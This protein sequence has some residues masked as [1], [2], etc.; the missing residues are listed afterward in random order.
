M[1]L[2]RSFLLVSLLVGLA[3]WLSTPSPH[4][5][6]AEIQY[7][8]LPNVDWN[9]CYGAAPLA[10]T[11]TC[12][13]NPATA[14]GTAAN[15]LA[16][17]SSPITTYDVLQVA[18]GSRMTM[19]TIYTPGGPSGSD[20]GWSASAPVANVT[21]QLDMGCDMQVDTVSRGPSTPDATGNESVSQP[22]PNSAVWN[23]YTFSNLGPT[24]TGE[25]AYLTQIKA[26]PSTFTPISHDRADLTNVWLGTNPLTH[27]SLTDV[28]S[29]VPTK[30]D[31]ILEGSPYRANLKVQQLVLGGNPVPPTNAF[32][33]V[34]SPERIVWQSNLFTPPQ[35]A[36]YYPRWAVLTSQPD[37]VDGSVARI[38]EMRC[39]V[40]GSPP[41][42]INGDCL[43]D[44]SEVAFNGGNPIAA[45]TSHDF[46]VDTVPNAVEVAVGTDPNSNDTDGDGATDYEELFQFTDPGCASGTPKY[47]CGAGHPVDT[48][49]TDG[50]GSWD[51][52]DDLSGFNCVSVNSVCTVAN[53]GDDNTDD[54]C[55][56]IFN[57]S[58]DNTDS[59][60]DFTNSPNTPLTAIYRGDATNPHQDHQGDVCDPDM[61]NDGLNNLAEIGG[62][63]RP[64]IPPGCIAVN[65]P[66]AS[67]AGAGPAAGTLWCLPLSA[68]VPT[69][70]STV[71][72]TDP[73]NPDSD[74]DGGL[75]GPECVFGSDPTSSSA[76]S[77]QPTC[78][79]SS[80]FPPATGND[81][82][83][84]LLFPDSAE[85]FYRTSGISLPPPSTVQLMDLEQPT[86]DGSIGSADPDSDGDRLNDGVE[87]KWYGTSPANFDT[88]GDGCSDG[89]E[90]ADINGN[91]KVD[92]T[93][94]LA[95]SQHATA[96][97]LAPGKVLDSGLATTITSTSLSDAT[98]DWTG[99]T[100]WV[101][102]QVRSGG[103]VGVIVSVT[104]G[105]G[106]SVLAVDAWLPV[107]PPAGR[108]SVAIGPVL[109]P[110]KVAYV[111]GGSRR[112]ELATYDLNK[113]GKID[114][115]DPLIAGNL[116]GN[117]AAGTGAQTARP[118]D[119]RP[120]PT[121]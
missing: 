57:P 70:G 85:L 8:D 88:D 106:T 86:P 114:S 117:C 61:D 60:P 30:L 101:G 2:R 63:Q 50:D 33:C 71:V 49:D 65:N 32:L 93:D 90:A 77:C 94:Q 53:L 118:I 68:P 51:K 55:P 73:L 41:P 62:F 78:S 54:N 47:S 28:Q 23:P 38:L 31:S 83:G 46:D 34:D 15:P 9:V 36:G 25:D 98:K 111:F 13:A 108:Y 7:F 56:N 89:R 18:Q 35:T 69:G 107:V 66:D 75:D 16:A 29:G 79:G 3:W 113:D 1:A 17:G 81:P 74:S 96:G 52:Q 11:M 76:S 91:H 120:T 10:G 119:R 67:C 37:P 95:I 115:T 39:L 21:L 27:L 105:L 82:D 116:F 92:S 100:S 43:T 58:Q 4:V 40:V 110:P 48:R 99:Q 84:D 121:P 104:G 59:R 64:N 45:N 5:A 102:R 42:D 6:N 103:S 19:P 24:P 22:W 109:G 44:S 80:R 72:Y 26:T 97:I 14:P 20:W 12:T 87:V 112:T